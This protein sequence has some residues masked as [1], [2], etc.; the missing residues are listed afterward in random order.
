MG[1]LP[2]SEPALTRGPLVLTLHALL[3][4]LLLMTGLAAVVRAF[5]THRPL[6]LAIAAL[7]LLALVVAWLTGARYVGEGA[8]GAS[9][10]MA[11]A[12]GVAIFSYVLIVFVVPSPAPART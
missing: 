9:L 10:A 8:N 6:L 4:T 11:I 5:M 7:A 2:R 12:T 3:G 1:C